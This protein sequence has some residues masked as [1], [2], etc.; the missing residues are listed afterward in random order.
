MGR[1][2]KKKCYAAPAFRWEGCG[3]PPL[4]RFALK[5]YH[6]QLPDIKTRRAPCQS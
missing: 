6:G 3:L 4:W 5:K 2:T 1:K